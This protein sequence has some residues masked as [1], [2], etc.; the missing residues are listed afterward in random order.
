MRYD[1]IE[2]SIEEE[3][4]MLPLP[5]IGRAGL[6]SGWTFGAFDED[7]EVVA[8]AFYSPLQGYSDTVKFD[9]IYVKPKMRGKGIAYRLT[10]FAE[11]IF[12]ENGAKSIYSKA[13]ADIPKIYSD[14]EF[15]QELG[16]LSVTINNWLLFYYYQDLAETEF[17]ENIEK[18]YKLTDS[19]ANISELSRE[20]LREFGEAVKKQDQ[21]YDEKND[22]GFFSKYYVVNNK[23]LGHIKFSETAPKVLMLTELQILNVPE[24]RLAIPAMLGSLLEASAPLL[25]EDTSFIMQ[26]EGDN[27]YNGI[28]SIFGEAEIDS[29]VCEF[30]KKLE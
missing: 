8:V 2:L 5:I 4:A 22:D 9:Y 25:K 15:M 20:Q 17:V 1:L 26:I 10:E 24:A 29:R 30:I 7:D 28:K 14:F 27:N 21:D 11:R 3:Q 12:S 16:F 23:I 13:I 6:E 19:T 18:Y